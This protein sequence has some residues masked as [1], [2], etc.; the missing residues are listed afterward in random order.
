MR[1]IHGNMLASILHGVWTSNGGFDWTHQNCTSMSLSLWCGFIPIY[2]GSKC[3]YM[4]I[5]WNAGECLHHSSAHVGPDWLH[6]PVHMVF[7]KK[8]FTNSGCC[9]CVYI[10]YFLIHRLCLNDNI[11]IYIY[12]N[13]D[14]RYCSWWYMHNIYIWLTLTDYNNTYIEVHI[15]GSYVC[16]YINTCKSMCLSICSIHLW[17]AYAN[18]MGGT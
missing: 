13:R 8:V 9:V 2:R 17:C 12:I 14:S 4:Y 10:C 15:D 6:I 16:N 7:A 18:K 5:Y 11:Y 1:K 3:I